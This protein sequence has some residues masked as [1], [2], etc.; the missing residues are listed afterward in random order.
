MGLLPFK[1]ALRAACTDWSGI[2][3]LGVTSGQRT[4]ANL[5]VGFARRTRH[6]AAADGCLRFIAVGLDLLPRTHIKA[7]R[8]HPMLLG[9]QVLG[10]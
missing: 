3:H 4:G 9:V 5:A 6:L 1:G 2:D 8:R 7:L 10:V